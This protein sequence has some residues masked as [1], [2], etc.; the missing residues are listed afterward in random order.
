MSDHNF[1]PV[2]PAFE[3]IEGTIQ[4]LIFEFLQSV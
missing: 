4:W 3:K 2:L 1:F